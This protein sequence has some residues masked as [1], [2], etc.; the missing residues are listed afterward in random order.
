MRGP[1]IRTRNSAPILWSCTNG[2]ASGTARRHAK[3]RVSFSRCA[4]MSIG[5]WT[6]CTRR[7]A[8]PHTAY[9]LCSRC[10]PMIRHYGAVAV[11][12]T[13]MAYHKCYAAHWAMA[14]T[15]PELDRFRAA[16]TGA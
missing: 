10:D 13:G 11:G 5:M 4:L 12:L 1:S 3:V 15:R 6:S 7:E 2:G 9:R 14:Q 16:H 8:S